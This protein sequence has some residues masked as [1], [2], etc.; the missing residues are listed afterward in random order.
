MPPRM[1]QDSAWDR[2]SRGLKPRGSFNLPLFSVRFPELYV[3]PARRLRQ[4]RV[5]RNR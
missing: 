3:L 5:R 2:I 4:S 1:G